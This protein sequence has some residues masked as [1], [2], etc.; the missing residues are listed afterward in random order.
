MPSVNFE[1]VLDMTGILEQVG[2]LFS[3]LYMS[4]YV[5]ICFYVFTNMHACSEL[6]PLIDIEQSQVVSELCP[7]V[8]RPDIGIYE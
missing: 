4:I 7:R 8:G 1:T 6:R 3:C 2:D 5:Y